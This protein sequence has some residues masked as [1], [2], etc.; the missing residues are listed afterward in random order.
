MTKRDVARWFYKNYKGAIDAIAILLFAISGISL[1][2][3]IFSLLL[4]GMIFRY[5]AIL[6]FVFGALTG[7]AADW[8]FEFSHTKTEIRKIYRKLVKNYR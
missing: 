8:L 7:I 4:V 5:W 3:G 1:L 6:L 2:F